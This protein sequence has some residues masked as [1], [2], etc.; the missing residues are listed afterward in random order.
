M[1][2]FDMLAVIFFALMFG[3]GL[4]LSPQRRAEPMT[5]VLEAL[6][7]VVTAIIDLVMKLAPYGVFALIFS[8]T[9]RF[10]YDLLVK[11]GLYVATV[12]L[13]LGIHMFVSFPVLVKLL[14]R[15]SPVDFF[16]RIRTII[17]T[18]FS[19]SSSN[20]TLPTSLRVTETELGVPKQICGFVLPL[21]ATMNMNGTALFEGVTVL[22]VAQVF[23]VDLNLGAQ[24]IVVLMSVVTAIGTAGVPSGSIPLLILVAEAVGVPGGGIA[25]VLGVDRILD[26]CRTTLNVT[27]DVT[28]AAYITRS[29]GLQFRPAAPDEG[30]NVAA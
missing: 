11:L 8:V 10:G 7:E 24:L 4:A 13:G 1:V 25:L 29:E 22:F 21:G 28:A 27:G 20:A 3:V 6:A 17:I 30:P 9:A 23:G 16:R 19:T 2:D 14:A 5:R 12:L 26:M 18:A 15:L